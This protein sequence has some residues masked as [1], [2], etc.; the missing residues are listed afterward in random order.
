MLPHRI[1]F[2]RYLRLCFRNIHAVKKP[3][4]SETFHKH[5]PKI[6]DKIL[7]IWH[8][9]SFRN[10]TYMGIKELDFDL[11]HLIQQS[12]HSIKETI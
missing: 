9:K 3:K 1:V 5:K 2:Y 7:I 11:K 6:K 12:T 4:L 10:L 8:F